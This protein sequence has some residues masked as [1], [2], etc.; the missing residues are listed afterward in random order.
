MNITDRNGFPQKVVLPC[1]PGEFEP[2]DRNSSKIRNPYCKNKIPCNATEGQQ[3]FC[4]G[5]RV[6]ED[7]CMC[8]P[9]YEPPNWNMSTSECKGGFGTNAVCYCVKAPCSPGTTRNI[10]YT[11][12]IQ[13]PDHQNSSMKVNY[14]CTIKND[15]T[16]PPSNVTPSHN[17]THNP[18]LNGQ[19]TPGEK[20]VDLSWFPLLIPLISLALVAMY[21]VKFRSRQRATFHHLLEPA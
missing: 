19:L 11:S 1:L 21:L 5:G 17:T 2:K 3:T 13:C 7:L 8:L 14:A 6:N 15:M 12:L 20:S 10:N 18:S 4:D 16:T 9:G